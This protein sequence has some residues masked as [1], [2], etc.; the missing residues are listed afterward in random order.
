M[1]DKN[2]L[3]G[4]QDRLEEALGHD[5]L[6]EEASTWSQMLG[7]LDNSMSEWR[8]QYFEER[9]KYAAERGGKFVSIVHLK[10]QIYS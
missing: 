3:P 2:K 7:V 8:P 4:I 9:K 6:V 5:R 10:T 1:M